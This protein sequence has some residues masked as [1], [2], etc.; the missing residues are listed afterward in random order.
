MCEM[1]PDDIIEMVQ[2]QA[3]EFV[4]KNIHRIQELGEMGRFL[5]ERWKLNDLQA[6]ALEAIERCARYEGY[7]EA[8]PPAMPAE[9]ISASE[10]SRM[11]ADTPPSMDD[12]IPFPP[13]P[14][15]PEGFYSMPDFLFQLGQTLGL[16]PMRF[17]DVMPPLFHMAYCDKIKAVLMER[18]NIEQ[19]PEDKLPCP[20]FPMIG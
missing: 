13:M 18:L 6:I 12:I 20:A 10:L 16:E 5:T 7:V 9:T 15:S 4:H 11:M 1:N 2:E 8:L 19:W 3:S 17:D 14:E